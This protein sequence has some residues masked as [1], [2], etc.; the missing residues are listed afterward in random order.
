MPV[1]Q[2]IFEIPFKSPLHA[3]V[4]DAVRRRWR[5]SHQ[6]MS[7][8]YNTWSDMEDRYVAYI[9]PSEEDR[10]RSDKRKSGSPQYTTIEVPYS[11][12]Q[13][14]AAHTYITSVFLSRNP[15]LQFAGRHGE[16]EM[17]IQAIEA[18]MDYQLQVGG[19][20][21]PL[22]IWLLDPLKYGIGVVGCYWEREEAVVTEIVMEPRNIAGIPIPGTEHRV[23]RTKI[24]TGY[25]GNKLYNVRPYDW[26]PDP[27]VPIGQFQQGEFAGR[28]VEAG[29]NH[30]RRK[31]ADGFYYNIEELEKTKPSGWM[32]DKG[33]ARN[34]PPN[35][36]SEAGN[37]SGGQAEPTMNL[38]IVELLE[39][40]VELIPKDWGLGSN[41]RPEKWLFVIGNDSVVVSAQ[42]LGF[43][44]NRF[45]FHVLEYEVEGY[46]MFKRSML[47]ILEPLNNTLTWLFNSHFYNVRQILN[48]QFV[49]DP[50]RITMKDFLEPD[51]GRIL[52]LK[53][54]A[55]GQ[56]VRTVVHQLQVQ[57]VTASHMQDAQRVMDLMQR[58]TGVSDPIM[59]MMNA[60]GRKS[61]TEVRT[62][63]TF[64]VNRLKT[65]A[66]YYSAQGF[67]PLSQMLVQNTQEKY[68]AERKFRVAGPLMA[69]GQTF[70]DVTPETL[71]G[72]YDYVPVDGSMPID[73]FAM[74]SLWQ[75][76][77]TQMAGIPS[78]LMEYDLA[79]IFAYVAH[80]AGVKN[81]NQFKV[82]VSP[83]E[84]LQQLA[85]AGELVP[86]GGRGGQ[87]R[88]GG[89]S[90]G[91]AQG[92]QSP[93]RLE[94]V[95]PVA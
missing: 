80:L 68:T 44:H 89:R 90:A 45:P 29:W 75:Q 35:P 79:E 19:M 46:A 54:A 71:Y 92:A 20:M 78:L 76:I 36:T 47:E 3:K 85:A 48:G 53:P 27:R 50:S 34:A 11:Y 88:A 59:G 28:Y 69:K 82:Q 57:D 26:F 60:G 41:D 62:S 30:I 61:A 7:E 56:D 12:A 72:F 1:A 63:S 55:Y 65:V 67:A 81:L 49:A 25:E 94:G 5:F 58:M 73:R 37:Q 93:A 9:K 6:R 74:A 8:R 14:L 2:G 23:K 64:G 33:S 18:I 22:Y 24:L 91:G 70:L 39:M 84:R 51:P 40:Y 10:D 31:K 52:R 86:I 38:D 77:L 15:V 87:R 13:V 4:L 42:P 43:A 21:V 16:T 95:G 32:R 83:D 17:S 66:E